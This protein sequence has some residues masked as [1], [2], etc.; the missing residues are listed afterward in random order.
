MQPRSQPGQ[1]RVSRP[2]AGRAF[3]LIELL[4]VIA[5]I[6]ILAAL[7]LPALAKAKLKAQAITCMNN[8]RQLMLA[9]RQYVEDNHDV[10]PYGYALGT[11]MQYAWIP[12]GPP[13]DLDL[14]SPTVQGNWDADNTI[15]QSLLWTYCGKNAGIWHCPADKSLGQKPSGEKVSRPRSMSMNL[16]VGGRGDMANLRGN[17]GTSANYKVFRKLGEM[18]VPGPAMTFVFLD[19]REDSINDGFYIVQMDGYPNLAQTVMVDYPASY[20]SR[21]AG[22]SFADGHAEI[23]KWLDSRTCPPLTTELNLNVSQPNNKDVLWMQERSTRVY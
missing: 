21:A 18:S 12:S 4:V 17:W 5:I 19:E 1:R 3:T 10:L 20:H 22:F 2:L 6:A 9:W 23:H 13:L 7:L 11:M 15:K 8:N 16:W 14:G